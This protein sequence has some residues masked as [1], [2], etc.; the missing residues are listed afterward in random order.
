LA[1]RNKDIPRLFIVSK[2][3]GNPRVFWLLAVLW[4]ALVLA[5]GWMFWAGMQRNAARWYSAYQDSQAQTK[6]LNAE[7]IELKQAL[8]NADRA[9]FITQGA[10]AQIQSGLAD[11]DEQI[12]GLK[13]D[14]DF[15]QRLVGASGQRH[16]LSVH[17]V[18]LKP[19]TAGAWQYTVT[20]TQNINR[21]GT[22][23][24]TLRL[25]VD[26]VQN[27]K[28]L[29]IEWPQLSQKALVSGQEFKFRY[30]QELQG[31]IVLPA[32]FMPQQVRVSVESSSGSVQQVLE[33]S[34]IVATN[35][36]K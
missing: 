5:W 27:G 2:V 23:D 31:Q 29:S 14:L 11:K 24:G 32:H 8:K 28:L 26:G 21:G 18:A 36:I 7:M 16:G 4:F 17:Q 20:L 33:W 30:F 13:A 10:N 3:T 25:G 15:Y 9:E 12:A 6:Q 1:V 35:A 34:K 22:T 19:A